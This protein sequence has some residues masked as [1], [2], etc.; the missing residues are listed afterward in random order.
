MIRLFK[1]KGKE[2]QPKS[3]RYFQLKVK[4]IRQET[5]DANTIIFEWPENKFSYSP[6]QFL[7]LILPIKGEEV[8]RSYSLCT[9][10]FTQDNPAITVKRVEAGL[11]SN[12][13]NDHMKPGDV[14]DVMAPA[15][16]FVPTLDENITKN[17]IMF[18]AGSGITPIISII[19]SILIK[20]SKDKIWLI[21]QN[22]DEKSIIFKERLDKIQDEYQGRFD[23]I[24]VLSQ[25]QQDW[26]G[27]A[28]RI[29]QTTASDILMDIAG[30]KINNYNY[31][32]CGPKGFMETATSTLSEFDVPEKLIHVE[33]FFTGDLKHKSDE[34][35]IQSEG[36]TNVKI[37][38]DGEE[39]DVEVASNKTIL[40]AALDQDIDMPFSCQ[41]GLC[42]ACRGKLLSGKVEME[43][44]DGL[45][46]EEI[47]NGYILN[48]VSKPSGEGVEIEIG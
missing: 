45:S 41:S 21:Y 48:C 43:E 7:T 20:G 2:N 46:E 38:L 28:G 39:Y 24:H 11:V 8:R 17:Y 6:G 44:D 9:S 30:N 4:E 40:E 5:N 15:G 36:K 1:K 13:L 23:Q 31:F 27:Y 12:Y 16:H 33:S 29:T 37:Q 35:S 19:E 34:K 32:I 22:R 47:K 25:P 14:F 3:D 10:P 42:T 18:A 26:Q